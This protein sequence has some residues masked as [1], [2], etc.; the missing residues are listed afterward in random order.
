MKCLLQHAS[1]FSFF[2]L[3]LFNDAIFPDILKYICMNY[4]KLILGQK[5][6]RSAVSF[7]NHY[8]AIFVARITRKS[9]RL[10]RITREAV[11]MRIQL[12]LTLPS[13]HV[14]SG[15]IITV[16]IIKMMLRQFITVAI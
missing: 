15:N 11:A 12:A 8:L 4:C 9:S 5:F 10:I 16:R 1:S 14:S 3:L 7:H 13:A 6:V 2:F